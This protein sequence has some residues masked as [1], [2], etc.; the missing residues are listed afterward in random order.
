EF[1][2][3]PLEH[4]QLA[5]FK[6]QKSGNY[7]YSDPNNRESSGIIHVLADNGG[8]HADASNKPNYKTIGIFV[9]P[10]QT[11]EYYDNF[12]TNKEYNIIST[13]VLGDSSD[14]NRIQLY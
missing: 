5:E 1:A 2:S 4:M 13:S 10:F 7:V 9:A 3:Q 14:I 12:F 11:K 6:F 8:N